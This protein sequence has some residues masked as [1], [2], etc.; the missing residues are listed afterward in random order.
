MAIVF[1]FF[2][3]TFF[4]SAEENYYFEF[5]IFLLNL[6]KI[7]STF[8]TGMICVAEERVADAPKEQPVIFNRKKFNQF[9]F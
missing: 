6:S 7:R 2:F 9:L 1:E 8:S 4:L 3:L 5:E